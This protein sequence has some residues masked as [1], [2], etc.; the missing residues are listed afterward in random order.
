MRETKLL[1]LNL[2]KAVLLLLGVLLAYTASAQN[3]VRKDISLN[4][5]KVDELVRKLGAE[6]P[7]SFFI[8]N[9]EVSE[10][11]VSVDIKNATVEQ[12]LTQAFAGKNV[13]FTR[14]GRN[15]TIS[16]KQSSAGQQQPS[17]KKPFS[18]K[19]TDSNGEPIIGVIVR[20]KGTN[21][22]VTTDING[23]FTMNV[24]NDAVLQIS[25]LGYVN[26]EVSVGGRSTLT[27]SMAEDMQS[28]DE[29]VV[30]GY[31]TQKKVN[32]IGSISQINAEQLE[33]RPAPVLSNTLAGL[34]PGVTMIQ[35]SGSPGV[36]AGELRIRGV[37][38]F[39]A[40][41]DALVLIDGIPGN[42]N[43]VSPEE[44]ASM[45]VLKDASSAAIYGARAANGVVL[46]TTKAGRESKIQI[47]YNG[48][49]GF[50][51]PTRLPEFLPS[52][53]Y[54][55]AFNEA[56]GTETYK[57]ED[58]QKFKDGSDPDKYPNSDFI[59]D[60][61]SRNGMQTGHDLTITGG[62]DKNSYHLTAGYLS[63]DGI[64]EKNNF[65]RYNARINMTN[66]LAT[67]LKLT[68]RFAGLTSKV[69]EPAVP[70]GKD[71]FRMSDGII[72]NAS[73]YPSVY[74]GI[75]SNDDYGVGP[76]GGGTPVA[77]MASKSFYEQPTWRVTTNARLDITPLDGLAIALI[78]GYNFSENDET[79]YRSTMRL[80]DVNT[81]G[82]SSLEEAKERHIYSTVQATANYVKSFSGHDIN[83]LAGYSFEKEEMR[84]VLASRDKFPGNDLPYLTVGS[85]DNQQASGDGWNWAI[86]SVF[87]RVKYDYSGRYLFEATVRYD[88]SS[89]FPPTRKFGTFPSLAAGWR[90]SEETFME[91]TKEWLSNLKL[92]ASWGILGNQNIGNYPWQSVYALGQN[93]TTGGSFNQG[94]AVTTYV[95]PTLHW[96]KTKTMDGGLEMTLWNGLLS[97]NVSYFNRKTTDVL[98]SP[99]A[100]VSTVLGMNLSRINTG[101]LQNTGWEFELSHTKRIG[102]FTW[103]VNGNFSIIQ[104]QVLDLGVGNVK[105]LNG[106]IGN[107]T[108][109]FIGYPMNLYYGYVTDGV[110]IDQ[111]D[112]DNWYATNNQQS[113][114]PKNTAR[115]GDFRYVDISGP[116]G[117]PDGIVNANYDRKVLGSTIPKYT[118]AFSLGFDYKGFDFNAF[119]QGV[120]SVNGRL[121]DYAGFAFFNLGSVQRWMW[122]GRFNPADPQ[123]YPAYPRLQIL[124]N[125]AG[126][127]GQL[128]NYWVRNASYLRLKNL[129]LGYTLPKKITQSLT[130]SSARFYVSAENL[131]TWTGYPK[132]WDPEINSSGEYYPLLATFIFGI[133]LKF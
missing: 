28:L 48:Y 53:E 19:I 76:E 55:L 71:V 119:F 77:W 89:R 14:N 35:R 6:Y 131:A 98:Y 102:D 13:T 33:G 127:N 73:R 114:M 40:T 1:K 47:N 118:Y 34:M 62:S 67:W 116:N 5:V 17:G 69:K 64:V 18:G 15:I 103:R 72:R 132:G 11:V 65:T 27:L 109:L 31:G 10:T 52:W 121:Q 126:N 68:T 20:E 49:A 133:N 2:P 112:I 29:L 123:R 96:E 66:S 39:G 56:S 91:S 8:A 104:N 113:L 16:S 36:S 122:E 94:S 108:D 3:E 74:A 41:P 38:S 46:I 92:K 110:F 30:V 82:P 115:P 21:N 23:D 4:A 59:G 26:Q 78:G 128:S 37:G 130:I 106:L 86:Q 88:G 50:V 85:P 25:Y 90:V 9:N 63:Q 111:Q 58:I 87:G 42:I 95:D 43:D 99:S 107:G 84:N 12:A 124:G 79:L 100:S 57:P 51:K 83:L 120:N 22:G 81:M 54:A 70:G 32:V 125:A 45:S 24:A 80:N 93:Y 101:S 117:V 75:L 44:V 129:Q 7:Y 105:Q 97:L 61:F 60:V